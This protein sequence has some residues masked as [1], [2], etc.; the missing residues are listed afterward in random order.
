[1][2]QKDALLKQAIIDKK[3]QLAAQL[4][5][6][7]KQLDQFVANAEAA[8]VKVD[9]KK[10]E[11]EKLQAEQEAKLQAIGKS[12]EELLMAITEHEKLI[13]EQEKKELDI[14]NEILKV[15]DQH[16]NAQAEADR[17][18]EAMLKKFNQQSEEFHQDY[19]K[20]NEKEEDS[21]KKASVI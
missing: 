2:L 20:N 17:Y 1:M 10:A 16:R 13:N 9:D 5:I 6:S 12:K 15:K 14:Q 19:N 3:K 7:Q 11:L 4:A 8:Q 21:A 18:S